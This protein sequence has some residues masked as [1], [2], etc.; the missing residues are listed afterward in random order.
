MILNMNM[1]RTIRYI[2]TLSTI[3]VAAGLAACGSGS[4]SEIVAQVGN[5]GSISKGTLDHWIPIEAAV[6]YQERPTSPVP[7]GVLP[8]PPDYVACIAYLKTAGQKLVESGPKPTAVQLKA[9]C[10]QRDQ[11]L[12]EITLNT[13]I[14]WDWTI[15]T[16]TALGLRASDAEVR[17]RLAEVKK[18][19]YS[20][21]TEYTDYLKA[22]GQTVADM[23]LR[24]RVQLFELK[25]QK[26]AATEKPQSAAQL[27]QSE[28]LL[29]GKRWATVTSCRKGYVVSACKQYRGSQ[30][31]G[32][33]N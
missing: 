10:R 15:G 14:G 17:Q 5:V 3:A 23:L 19:T 29:S 18:A 24:S 33:P 12:K 2:S 26:R 27:Q 31:P 1:K 30:S 9:K 16:G 7:R 20:K 8:D 21:E 6:L 13:L 22:T 11:E 28:S 25:M 32:L 4:S